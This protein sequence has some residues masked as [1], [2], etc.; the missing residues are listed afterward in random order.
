MRQQL[1]TDDTPGHTDVRALDAGALKVYV[2]AATMD[3][4]CPVN[5]AAR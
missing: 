2:G 5:D 3:V 1:P 4:Q